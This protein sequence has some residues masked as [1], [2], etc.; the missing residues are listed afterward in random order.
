MIPADL[1]NHTKFSPDSETPMAEM[2]ARAEELGIRFFG[3]TEHVDYDYEAFGMEFLP[4]D[5]SACRDEL[6]KQ[7]PLFAPRTELLFGA[8]FAFHPEA[9]SRYE[10]LNREYPFDYVIQSVHAVQGKDPYFADYFEGKTKEKAYADYFERVLES[11]D[12]SYCFEILGHVGYCMRGAPYADRLE[13]S[14][15]HLHILDEIFRAAIR[16]ETAV[17]INTN[18]RNC[19]S[20]TLPTPEMLARYRKLGGRLITFGSDAHQ[21]RRVGENRDYAEHLAKELG[22]SSWCVFRK[23]KRFFLPVV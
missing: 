16:R 10:A 5:L 11:L 15:R 22:F 6:R 3:I 13:L 17:E 4:S 1:H 19:G 7:K 23:R 14:P 8:E 21:P 2:A 12:A 20:L 9:V 18:V